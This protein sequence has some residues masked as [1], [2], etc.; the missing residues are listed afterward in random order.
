MA[1][2]SCSLGRVLEPV[3][4]PSSLSPSQGVWVLTRSCLLP[5]YQTV[6]GSLF[7]SLVVKRAILLV[8]KSIPVR[9]ILYVVVLLMCSWGELSLVSSYSAILMPPSRKTYYMYLFSFLSYLFPIVTIPNIH[10]SSQ[11]AFPHSRRFSCHS[12]RCQTWL[13]SSIL[14][15]EC[16][17]FFFSSSL[18]ILI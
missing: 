17:S 10:H 3:I 2:T 7:Y 11:V 14:A 13:F 9:V 16:V 1:W 15:C 5:S 8:F 6:C 18:L 12:L 4:S